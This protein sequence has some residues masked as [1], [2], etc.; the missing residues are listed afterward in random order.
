MFLTACK[1][2]SKFLSISTIS[3]PYIVSW[4]SLP[5]ATFP[6][7][8]TIIALSPAF[9]AYAAAEAEV[10]PVDAQITTLLPR[11]EEHTS[12]LQSRGHLV[13]RLLLEK[14]KEKTTAL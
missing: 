13:C 8:I 12:E 5:R 1:A 4:A 9:A 2:S 11:S 3:A 10:L 14:K 7:G 6:F